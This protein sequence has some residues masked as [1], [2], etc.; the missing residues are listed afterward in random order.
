[1]TLIWLSHFLPYPPRGGAPQRS[2]HLLREASRHHEIILVA[3]NRPAVAGQQL[4]SYS[5]ELKE[6][7]A[8]VEIWELPFK[9]R[10]IRWWAGLLANTF[11]RLPY[12]CEVY[13]SQELTRRW[14]D[15]LRANPDALV[16]IDS[17]DL[18]TYIRTADA[19]RVLLNHHNCE[20]AMAERR[21]SVEPNPLKRFLLAEQAKRQASLERDV[22]ARVAVNA[23]VSTEDGDLLRH[24]CPS[25][26]VHV[27]ANGTDTDYFIPDRKSI[28]ENTLVFA[29]SL[30][31]YPNVS[32]LRFFKKRIWPRLK[33]EI[34]DLRCILAGKN[35]VPEIREWADSDS[36]ITLVA[37]PEDIRP[38][39]A[40]G[41]VFVCPVI[42]G[43]GTRL[44]L[45]D[46][47]SSGKAIVT[48]QIGAE[49]LG[50][51]SGA[52][53][54][55]ANSDDEFVEMTLRLLRDPSF[56]SELSARA[57]EYVERHFS[58]ATIGKDL[59]AAYSSLEERSTLTQHCGRPTEG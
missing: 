16:H 34:K 48:T 42:D 36:A 5:A 57:R 18:A 31:W 59:E 11:Q 26:R 1:M 8:Q 12:S 37:S 22:C 15:I 53:A 45:L 29:G 49:G 52:Q 55:I 30:R 58:W 7:C 21:A 9:W 51:E 56:R 14:G 23:V 4:Q 35:P 24:Q 28:R 54:M 6:F 44:K 19:T 40:K 33:N 38:W 50:I 20:S 13:R 10:G 2:Y 46:A 47:M 43:G 39:I 3:F 41:A 27:V 32:G 25:A 17:S